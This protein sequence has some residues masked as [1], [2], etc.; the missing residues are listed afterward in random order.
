MSII[1]YKKQ[2]QN[3]LA[4]NITRNS[5]VSSNYY[6]YLI[7]FVVLSIWRLKIL[8]GRPVR[9][10]TGQKFFFLIQSLLCICG[11]PVS[12]SNQLWIEYVEKTFKEVPKSKT[13]TCHAQPNII[14]I[15]FILYLH[16]I[17]MVL[18]IK[19]SA[20]VKNLP[21]SAGDTDLTPGLGWSPA[22]GNDKPLQYSGWKTLVERGAL[23]ARVHGITKRP[24]WLSNEAR[25]RT[26]VVNV[27]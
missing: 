1:S 18:C 7:A 9:K 6:Y 13:W 25:T 8:Q 17:Y 4:W 27:L 5:S 23:W 20:V 11:L 21:A 3:T 19:G 12:R 16:S 24:T 15:A 10:K 14:L 22:G 26:Q 2:K